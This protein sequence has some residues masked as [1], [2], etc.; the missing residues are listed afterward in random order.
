MSALVD[1]FDALDAAEAHRR[2]MLAESDVLLERV[3]ALR[4]AG[5]TVCPGDLAESVRSLLIRLG[6]L[7]AN[8]PH[9]VRAAHH[10]V[11]AV[12]ARLMAANPRHP[13]PRALPG[14]PT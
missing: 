8:R 3:E 1:T 7:P 13:R 4:L 12:Q 14:R 2:G 9:S 10:M 6:R 11:F 5:R